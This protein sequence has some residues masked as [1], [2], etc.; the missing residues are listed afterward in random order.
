MINSSF[1]VNYI[2]IM[3]TIIIYNKNEIANTKESLS[4]SNTTEEI[5]YI[6]NYH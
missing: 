1:K 3:I 4:S 6:S 2:Y 5:Y